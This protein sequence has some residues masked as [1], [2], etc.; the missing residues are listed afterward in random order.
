MPT[1]NS[2]RYSDFDYN[3]YK[4]NDYKN[5]DYTDYPRET[6]SIPL[7][8]FEAEEGQYFIGETGRQSTNAEHTEMV[9][10][11]NPLNSNVTLHIDVIAISNFMTNT[12]LIAT[13]YLGSEFPNTF[14]ITVSTLVSNTNLTIRHL[15]NPEGQIQFIFAG[16]ND[17]PIGGSQIFTRIVPQ[18]STVTDEIGGK[19]ILPP[20]KKLI[21]VIPG[22]E[23]S[24][25]SFRWFEEP[26]KRNDHC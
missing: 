20:G 26:I 15:P 18:S 5:N 23:I 19:I 10:I 25:V 11:A 3:H 8:L 4:N 13:I 16:I 21:V 22:P 7:S 9:A 12:S 24:S 1:H 17:R 6:V 2:N 14:P